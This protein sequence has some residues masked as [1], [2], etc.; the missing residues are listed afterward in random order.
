MPQSDSSQF[1]LLDEELVAYLDGQLDPESARQVEQRLASEEPVRRRLQQL[2]Q[3]WDMLDQLPHAVADDTFT[4]STVQMVAVAAEQEMAEQ[5]A[6]VPQRQRRRWLLAGVLAVLAGSCGFLLAAKLWSDPNE[7]LLRDLSTIENVEA[8]G[9]VGDIEFLRKL[10]EEGLFPDDAPD[11][12]G[13]R[14]AAGV[15]GAEA[16]ESRSSKEPPRSGSLD[17]LEERRAYLAK[18][19]PQEKEELRSKFE[20]FEALSPEKQDRLRKFDEELNRDPNEDR[21]RRVMGRFADWLKTLLTTERGELLNKTSSTA[22]IQQIRS[23]RHGQE[24]RLAAFTGASKP[25][26][27][28]IHAWMEKFAKDHEEELIKTAGQRMQK[29]LS[30]ATGPRRM[31]LLTFVAWRHWRTDPTGKP[32]EVGKTI[33]ASE[34]ELED[35][36]GKLSEAARQKLLAEPGQPS[37]N[38]KQ[39]VRTVALANSFNR[40][41]G[42]RSNVSADDLRKVFEELPPSDRDRLLG[43]PR[44]EMDRELRDRA[45]AKKFRQQQMSGGRGQG[46]RDGPG[47][48]DGAGLGENPRPRD[49]DRG[50]PRP[51][52]GPNQGKPP[53]VKETD[54]PANAEKSPRFP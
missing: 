22:R 12:A 43:L 30:A 34:K 39:L 45:G 29:E 17:T 15:A 27:A 20:M 8:Y 32:A 14:P 6:V 53:P 23:L 50:N 31:Q 37:D 41:A 51:E 11:P 3:S 25:D 9:Q 1:A 48:R 38:I 10:N 28:A 47:P 35:L 44:E 46:S 52:A 36:K 54:P 16:D 18:M 24:A 4:R 19:S 21:L 7:Q 13:A 26:V 42:A 2:A 33:N 49:R 40:R 5:Q